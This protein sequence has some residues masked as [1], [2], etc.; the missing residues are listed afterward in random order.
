MKNK[1]TALKTVAQKKLR[2]V[3]L[4]QDYCSKVDGA[5]FFKWKW[6]KKAGKR[7]CW[8]QAVGYKTKKSFSSGPVMC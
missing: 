8:C 1:M 5:T 4:C 3:A 2:T 6:N 7:I